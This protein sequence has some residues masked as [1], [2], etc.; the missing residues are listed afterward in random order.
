MTSSNWNPGAVEIVGGAGQVVTYTGGSSLPSRGAVVFVHPINTSARV[1]H[2]VVGLL[3]IDALA[4]D[5]RGHGRSAQVGPYTVDGY[6]EDVVAAMDAHGVEAAHLV[7]GSLGGTISA[8][9]AAAH[10]NRVLSV[11]A[12]G[13]TLGTGVGDD[14][15]A[16]MV[17]ELDA[18]GMTTYFAELIPQVLGT[19]FRSPEI[20]AVALEAIGDRPESVVADILRGAFGADIRD[21]TDR[22]SAPTH[23][24]AGTEDPTCPVAMSTEFAAATGGTSAELP[25]VG[26]LPMV[27]TP[28]A[29]AAILEQFWS[30]SR[31]GTPKP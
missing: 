14:A 20:V 11:A 27:E 25:G 4:L 16:A 24:I 18:A 15:I 2:E 30:G 5:L 31:E 29:V 26:H 7:G 17:A 19:Q 9:T 1:W 21:R 10:P 23:A 12:F 13:S 8:A 3:G 6:V 22:I 28:A